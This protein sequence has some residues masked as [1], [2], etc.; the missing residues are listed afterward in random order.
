MQAK[1][2]MEKSRDNFSTT[3]HKLCYNLAKIRLIFLFDFLQW[4]V[5]LGKRS[6]DR[7][8]ENLMMRA[9]PHRAYPMIAA[10]T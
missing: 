10:S 2:E 7:R 1:R 8:E 5:V 6:V 9:N 4:S 3:F